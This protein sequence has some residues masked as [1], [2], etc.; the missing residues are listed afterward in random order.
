VV[1]DLDNTL[2]KSRQGSLHAL[3]TVSKIIADHLRNRGFRHGRALLLKKLRDIE[4]DRRAPE[5]GFVPK[6]L[7][8]RDEWWNT[9]LRQLQLERL[10]G[11]WLHETTLRY[12]DA[13]MEESPPFKDAEPTV[14]GLKNAGMKLAIVSDSDGTPGMKRTRIRRLPFYNLF[15][16]VVVAG[17][18][19]PKV[20]PSKAPFL[21]VA[22][23]LQLPPSQC[24]YVGDNPSTDI[25]GAQ[26]AGM[27][28]IL[29]K[30]RQ[31]MVLGGLRPSRPTYRVRTLKEVPR[32][33]ARE[34][35]D[36]RL[37]AA[38]S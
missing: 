25:E 17:E 23:R 27:L 2:I 4:R 10:I 35:Q 30:R 11:P 33:L 34:V 20:K 38:R 1:F 21:L 24:A 16:T 26:Q 6:A 14:R 31:Y 18:D 28:T 19:T 32:V 7:Y 37:A 3:R 36:R 22:R 12:W 13:Y 29:V 8:D 15:E 9:L 5:S